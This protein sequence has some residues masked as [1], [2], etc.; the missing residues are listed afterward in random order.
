M[1]DVNTSYISEQLAICSAKTWWNCLMPT[2]S[3]VMSQNYLFPTKAERMAVFCLKSARMHWEIN[4]PRPSRL[5]SGLREQNYRPREISW[6]SGDVFPFAS[7]MQ[8]T[9]TMF[10]WEVWL[11][12][13]VLSR[14]RRCISGSKR[15][16]SPLWESMVG[17]TCFCG[18]ILCGNM[19]DPLGGNNHI[20][21][22]GTSRWLAMR[23][24]PT[25]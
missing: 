21:W 2:L 15:A 20:V 16:L 17:L 7:L 22:R 3:V 13:F 4:P 9:D 11:S 25:T 6:S 8:W 19:L 1:S 18:N 24:H 12:M 14:T 23:P 10:W 5:S